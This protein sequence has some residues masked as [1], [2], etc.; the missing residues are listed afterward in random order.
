MI[1][2]QAV[3][4][5]VKMIG[6]HKNAEAAKDQVAK[7]ALEQEEQQ[8]LLDKEKVEFR[9]GTAGGGNQARQPYLEKYDFKICDNLDNVNHVHDYGLYVGNHPELEKEQIIDLCRR[10]NEIR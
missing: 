8:K 5:G 9:V 2:V 7:A 10:L 3:S 6:S 4:T 1:A